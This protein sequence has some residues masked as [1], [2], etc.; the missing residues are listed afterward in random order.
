[1]KAIIPMA[2]SGTRLRPFTYSKPKAMLRVG[3]QPIIF[4]IVD[5]LVSLGC[6]T[7]ILIIS[8]EGENIPDFLR[9]HYPGINIEVVV[10]EERLGLGHAVFLAADRARDG[11]LIVMYGDTIIDGALPDVLKTDADGVIVVKKVDDP[12]RFGVVN[13]RQGYISKFV[14]KPA[15]P[16]SNLAIVGFNYFRKPAPLFDCL[17]ELI[18]TGKRTKGEFQITDAFQLMLG[19]GYT[20][21]PLEVEGWYDCGTPQSLLET[22]R[23]LLAREGN[24]SERENSIIIPPVFIPENAT[25]TASIIGP[26]VSVGDGAVIERSLVSDSIIGSNA[27]VVRASLVGSLIGDNAEIIERPRRLAVGDNSSLDFELEQM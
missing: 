10:Q 12:R 17:D 20:F 14:E 25:I 21:K 26:N 7:L 3:S 8:R 27:R 13:I 9:A 16:K 19:R 6:D 11:E 4:H 24:I 23:F 2:G 1:M 22:N 5:S 15:E 18:R